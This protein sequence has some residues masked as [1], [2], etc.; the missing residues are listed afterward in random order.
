MLMLLNPAWR[1][2]CTASIAVVVEGL[3]AEAHAVESCVEQ[4]VGGVGRDVRGVGFYRDF[5]IG[6][7]VVVVPYGLHD[8]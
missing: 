2:V 1:S 5:G 3:Y 8:L 7:H 4:L 6:V